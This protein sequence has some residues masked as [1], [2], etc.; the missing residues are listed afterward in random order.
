MIGTRTYKHVISSEV[1]NIAGAVGIGNVL[2][3]CSKLT[4]KRKPMYS[5]DVFTSLYT[6]TDIEIEGECQT[7]MGWNDDYTGVDSGILLKAILMGTH[8]KEAISWENKVI[9]QSQQQ[10]AR[11]QYNVANIDKIINPFK[12]IKIPET[13]EAK[14]YYHD[15]EFEN[16]PFLEKMMYEVIEENASGGAYRLF[17]VPVC[18]YFG[19]IT[20]EKE[21]FVFETLGFLT[22][23]EIQV[24]ITSSENN[25]LIIQFKIEFSYRERAKTLSK[26]LD[27][28]NKDVSDYVYRY[29]VRYDVNSMWT[30]AGIYTIIYI[31]VRQLFRNAGTPTDSTLVGASHFI[32][33][34][35]LY[36]GYIESIETLQ[37]E[38]GMGFKV[39]VR[40][41]HENF[42][43]CH[44]I[45]KSVAYVNV[46]ENSQFV[47]PQGSYAFGSARY[48]AKIITQGI[49]Q[50]GA[51][52]ST[53]QNITNTALQTF[54]ADYTKPE[55]LVRKTIYESYPLASAM[56]E[57]QKVHDMMRIERA[58]AVFS[59]APSITTKLIRSL[60]ISVKGLPNSHPAVLAAYAA[61]II[62]YYMFHWI[63]MYLKAVSPLING[64][65]FFNLMF[66]VFGNFNRAFANNDIFLAHE[67]KRMGNVGNVFQ[68]IKT[69]ADFAEKNP[70]FTLW[71]GSPEVRALGRNIGDFQKKKYF[72]TFLRQNFSGL[73]LNVIKQA[74]DKFKQAEG[75]LADISSAALGLIQ[76]VIGWIQNSAGEFSWYVPDYLFSSLM[77]NYYNIN[78][79]HVDENSFFNSGI[80][81][82]LFLAMYMLNGIKE[83]TYSTSYNV[84][85]NTYEID[86]ACT[87]DD[88]DNGA[89]SYYTSPILSHS[90]F[91]NNC[92]PYSAIP[93]A[94]D[95]YYIFRTSGFNDKYPFDIDDTLK[96]FLEKNFSWP[97]YS[98]SLLITTPVVPHYNVYEVYSDGKMLTG[99]Y[100][101]T[102]D[103]NNIFNSSEQ[104]SPP[105]FPGFNIIL[106]PNKKKYR[107]YKVFSG[108][109]GLMQYEINVKED[110]RF[111]DHQIPYN[112]LQEIVDIIGP[113]SYTFTTFE[114]GP[115][116]KLARFRDFY[117]EKSKQT[118]S[119]MN[120][121]VSPIVSFLKYYS[122]K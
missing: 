73:I 12:R 111:Y 82:R 72:L 1:Y 89:F 59:G 81:Y 103:A 115:Y 65:N 74:K 20:D 101:Y 95:K 118:V 108:D 46:I 88:W 119:G 32:P 47:P 77:Q 114:N 14:H 43:L 55:E 60:K 22:P 34:L 90:L 116:N 40:I 99:G 87:F 120:I 94:N 92:Y 93:Y 63:R 36:L 68:L 19:K 121:L 7:I 23:V 57:S 70:Y 69:I 62:D 11:S 112:S 56:V 58:D 10:I 17:N 102:G 107:V 106:D 83:I 105:R 79:K 110:Y 41:K 71:I 44:P 97:I 86:F 75:I 117:D 64:N 13:I 80:T 98:S 76:K 45:D 30:K 15:K 96:H 5:K 18:V 38:D 27:P 51:H 2:I 104:K 31:T 4:M 24:S 16:I 54:F 53:V 78:V 85:E 3:E 113:C 84:N 66:Y 9:E 26:S 109:G 61:N 35:G 8:F 50:A 29:T 25:K 91:F 6:H 67:I 49:E 100:A 122:G 39:V 48:N 33:N 28:N 21:G 37:H 52:I 42:V